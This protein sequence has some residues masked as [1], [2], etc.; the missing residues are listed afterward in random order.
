[1]R[2]KLLGGAALVVGLAL[3][4]N[5]ASAAPGCISAAWRMFAACHLEVGEEYGVT[6]ANCDNIADRSDRRSCRSGARATRNEESASCSD[7]LGARLDACDLLEEDRYD[8]DPLAD[9]AIEFIDP[10]DIPDEEDP[11]P[12][13]SLAAGR[14]WV[15]RASDG[16][17][18]EVVVVHVTGEIR[19]IQDVPCRIVV[20]SAVEVDA[21]PEETGVV[22]YVPLE[23]TDDWYAQDEDGDVYYCGELSRN[24]EDGLLTDLDGSFEAGVEYAKGGVL[25]RAFPTLGEAH[26][27]EFALGEAEDIVQYVDLAGIPID[28]MGGEVDNF[29]CAPDGC[30]QTHDSAPLDPGVTEFKYYI[31]N[32]GFVLAVSMEDGEITGEREEL[33]CVGDSLAIL[34]DDACD[35]ADPR[36]CARRC[37][38]CHRT[39]AT[40]TKSEGVKSWHGP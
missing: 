29:P 39:S 35:I 11:N 25:I 8:P 31:P 2:F 32:T 23:V 33:I 22:E 12:Y 28:E 30:L 19:E 27:Q 20:D 34:E 1:M 7:V 37:A 16:E 13:L 4:S 18:E 5:A 3:V 24:F 38:S 17:D 36:L 10:D 14:T 40:T 26:R 21:D 15:L 6:L 9:P